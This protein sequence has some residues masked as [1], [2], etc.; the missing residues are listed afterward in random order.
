MAKIVRAKY[1][2]Y[3]SFKIPKGINLEDKTQVKWWGIKYITLFIVFVD[4]TREEMEIEAEYEPELDCKYADEKTIKEAREY[5]YTDSE[6]DDEEEEDQDDF[7]NRMC[8]NDKCKKEFD[9]TEPHYYDEEQG[10]CYCCKE[11]FEEDEAP[12]AKSI[13]ASIIANVVPT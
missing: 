4:E 5:G 6:D 11:C 13:V 3:T 9:L 8:E 7:T 2:A 10:V 1:S 12:T